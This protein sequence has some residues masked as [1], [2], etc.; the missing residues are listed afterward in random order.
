MHLDL[1]LAEA[2]NRLSGKFA[3]DVK[4][5]DRVHEHIL[6]FADTLTT[7]IQNQFPDKFK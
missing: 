7:G 2:S 4:D 1:T 5:Y 6:H 3:E